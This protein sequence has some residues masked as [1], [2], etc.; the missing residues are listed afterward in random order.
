M[1]TP[2]RVSKSPE[3]MKL[4]DFSRLQLNVYVCPRL[5]SGVWGHVPPENFQVGMLRLA[6]NVWHTTKFPDFS[7]LFLLASKFPVI[8]VFHVAGHPV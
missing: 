4:P 7:S 3:G 2:T 1:G 6:D 8:Q 5:F